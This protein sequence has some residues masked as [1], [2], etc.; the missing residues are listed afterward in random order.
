MVYRIGQALANVW[1]KHLCHPSA[2]HTPSQSAGDGRLSCPGPRLSRLLGSTAHVHVSWLMGWGP[3]RHDV[4]VR[5]QQASAFLSRPVSGGSLGMKKGWSGELENSVPA[6]WHRHGVIE[7]AWGTQR[8]FTDY[9]LEV[10]RPKLGSTWRLSW[11]ADGSDWGLAQPALSSLALCLP[12]VND[13]QSLSFILHKAHD[14]QHPGVTTRDSAKV[15]ALKSHSSPPTLPS[16]PLLLAGAGQWWGCSSL[17]TSAGTC[18]CPLCHCVL[19][20]TASSS[21]CLQRSENRALCQGEAD[22]NQTRLDLGHPCPEG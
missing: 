6:P 3:H 5:Q 13:R 11:R 4:A 16:P 12:A 22:R 1:P 7:A 15:R 17:P 2:C 10:V 14:G 20:D 9:V 21:L 19:P 18:L 8:G